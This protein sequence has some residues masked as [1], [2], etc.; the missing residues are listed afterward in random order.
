MEEEK[1]DPWHDG[2]EALK[3]GKHV[4][5][6]GPHG[7]GKTYWAI[8]KLTRN[9]KKPLSVTIHSDLAVQDLQGH[10]VPDYPKWKVQSGPVVKAFSRGEPL[11]VNELPR[12]SASVLDWFLAVFDR[13]DVA[14]LV[15]SDAQRIFYQQGFQGVAT[16]N[17]HPGDLELALADRFT[18]IHVTTPHPE[19]ITALN[20][21]LPGLGDFI[22]ESY[23]DPQHRAISPRGAFDL[24]DFIK[25][26]VEL[27]QAV[28]LAFGEDRFRD[29]FSEL[30]KEGVL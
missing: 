22:L 12:G 28:R 25:F 7:T 23:K 13:P 29:I 14:Q 8:K 1:I 6:H 9:R 24:I 16:S 5:L 26:N 30:R 21:G 10:Y 27:K 15:L 19:I 4:F 3:C 20:K 18:I 2:D 11:V 17:S